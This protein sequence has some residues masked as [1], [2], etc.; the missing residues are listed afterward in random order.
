MTWRETISHYYCYCC[1]T[2]WVDLTPVN[3]IEQE[4]QPLLLGWPHQREHVV[5]RDLEFEG[6]VIRIWS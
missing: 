3:F 5:S 1:R 4:A 2:D 6:L